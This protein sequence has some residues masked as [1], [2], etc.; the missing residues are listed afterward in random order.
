MSGLAFDTLAYARRMQEVGFTRQQAEA[1]AEEQAKLIDDRLATKVDLAQLEAAGKAELA[2]VEASLR[3]DLAK[4]E[5]SLRADLAMVEAS[6]RA[7]TA[8]LEAG[9]RREIELVKRD[10]V[11]WLVGGLVVATVIVLAAFH[12]LPHSSA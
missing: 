9:L 2:K 12:Y 11:L 3:A 4:V 7:E 5:A 8:R 10:L 6:L 1:M